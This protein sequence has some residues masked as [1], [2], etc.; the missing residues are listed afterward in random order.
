MSIQRKPS[1]SDSDSLKINTKGSHFEKLFPLRKGLFEKFPS[2]NKGL[3]FSGP[4]IK[5]GDGATFTF[6]SNEKSEKVDFRGKDGINFIAR[7][8]RDAKLFDVSLT[9]KC[10]TMAGL[11]YLIKYEE[12]KQA[13][14]HY[15]FGGTY[16]SRTTGLQHTFKYN[17][18]TT[19]A[20]ASL[21]HAGGTCGI[22][23]GLRLAGDT[24]LLLNEMCKPDHI[25]F[26]VGL[27]Y[28]NQLGQTG[29]SCNQNGEVTLTHVKQ[30]Y[31]KKLVLGA[32]VVQSICGA[33]KGPK[34]PMV[35]A[36]SYQVDTT[37]LLRAKFNKDLMLNLGVKKDFSKNLSV[38]VG[39]SVALQD[40]STQVPAFGF[41]VAMKP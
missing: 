23:K 26:N 17:P 3:A 18:A 19:K 6:T 29:V 8:K 35:V 11:S 21:L 7:Y 14:P 31:D 5:V 12:R 15:V 13:A 41:K 22:P 38:S 39:T 30:A 32:E 1:F 16:V 25:L 2:A 34:M 4:G 40:L 9:G 37:T 10:E 33:K 20:K 36:A 27:A 24:E 28:D